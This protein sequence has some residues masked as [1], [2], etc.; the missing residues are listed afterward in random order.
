M[1]ER[2]HGKKEVRSSILLSGSGAEFTLL[3]QECMIGYKQ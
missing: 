3:V 2:L 1:A